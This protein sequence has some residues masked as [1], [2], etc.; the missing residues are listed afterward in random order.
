[1]IVFG[2]RLSPAA[3]ILSEAKDLKLTTKDTKIARRPL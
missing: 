2:G 3:I 1:M